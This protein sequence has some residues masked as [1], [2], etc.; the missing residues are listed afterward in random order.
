MLAGFV[1]P[2]AHFR[3][4][5]GDPAAD[6]QHAAP[7][8]HF[9][10]ALSP[11]RVEAAP[12]DLH[13]REF[14]QLEVQVKA[15][16]I[17]AAGHANPRAMG[18]AV[19]GALSESF[20][21]Y[22]RLLTVESF[23]WPDF[24]AALFTKLAEHFTARFGGNLL[25]F[26]LAH[27]SSPLAHAT[28]VA[29][30]TLT[31]QLL[32]T[33][34]SLL[35]QDSALQT[36]ILAKVSAEDRDERTAAVEAA[37]ALLPLSPT[38]R[39]DIL[40]LGLHS[41]ST[42]LCYLLGT[43][44]SSS[45]EAQQAWTHC[46]ELYERL[47]DGK[48][49]VASVR[50]MTTL[51]AAYPTGL[52][53]MHEQLLNHVL[54]HDP[55][56]LVRNFA[57]LATQQLVTAGGG[58]D[59]QLARVLEGIFSRLRD[60]QTSQSGRE[61]RLKLSALLLLEKWSTVSSE[62]GDEAVN[63]LAEAKTWVVSEKD[64]RFG[65]VY[66]SI[67]ANVAQQKLMLAGSASS[68]QVVDDLLLLLHPS[69]VAASIVTWTHALE[70]VARLSQQFPE[71]L[72]AYVSS[73]LVE[74][75]SI[76]SDGSNNNMTISARKTAIFRVLSAQLRPP[77]P[78]IIQMHLPTLLRE[79]EQ[80]GSQDASLLRAL[81]ATFFNWTQDLSPNSND[82]AVKPT[83]AAFEQ[84][85]LIAKHYESHAERY[86]MTKLAVLH[87]RFALAGQLVAPIAAQADSECFGGWL[88]ALQ[89][90]CEAEASVSAD[91]A[92][93]L[94]SLHAL[95]RARTFLQ[96]AR[97][98]SFR[99]EFQLHLLALRLEW[100]QLVQ[101]AQQLAGEAVFTNTAGNPSGREGQLSSQFR[102][103]GHKFAVLH[104]SL[105]GAD[106]SDLDVLQ[107]HSQ[108]CRLLAAALEGF[109]LLRPMGVIVFPRE[110]ELSAA[111][112]SH[113]G[114]QV[115]GLLTADV[116][117]K[118][119][120]L[121]KLS[122]ARQPGVGARVL[123]QLLAAACA[124]SCALPRLFFR[125]RLRAE[126]RLL[127]S[128]QFLTYAENAAFTAKPRSRSQ[129]GVPLGTDFTSVL[130][131]VL[132]LSSSALKH[133]HQHAE[134][135]EV[136]VLVCLADAASAG[137]GKPCLGST[138]YEVAAATMEDKLVQHRVRV[139]LPIAW[140][141]VAESAD[142]DDEGGSSQVT[143]YLPFETPVHVKA[144]SL[145]LK[146][147][148]LLLAKLALVDRHGQRWPLAATGCRRGFIVY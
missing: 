50:A 88:M 39:K 148:F 26:L 63:L 87:G 81:A 141:Q 83:I 23:P 94:E 125:S 127:S 40:T 78:N 110:M 54:D 2:H 131:G 45:A 46:A 90:L 113:K 95:T 53:G 1:V 145:K 79:L 48:S 137:V 75:L 6:S 101:R 135:I 69:G 27:L 80:A 111:D 57:L 33:M 32:A 147:S 146:G 16:Q 118:L 91:Q 136:E 93:Q 100:M 97:T 21:F 22:S 9:P 77:S 7:N 36:Q 60:S 14:A 144:A 120:R 107:S 25:R 109:L 138:I 122:P 5:H 15:L 24:L 44:V 58:D 123:Q 134:A 70:A 34:P 129:L 38:F 43:A 114:L 126:R 89:A 68:E 12:T 10:L 66:V 130:K 104:A 98:S 55:R 42:A 124:L 37:R 17:Q 133:W 119:A 139:Q 72:A 11:Q 143:L 132:A 30:R 96:A 74:L 41:Y 140:D 73:R 116:R 4:F 71:F 47:A 115:W 20:L 86:E 31:L 29:T 52:L 35:L 84:Q 106:Q 108:S 18:A 67:L 64:E 28:S 8:D 82:D 121:T 51:T 103:L 85:F 76:A 92:V 65:K 142:G 112:K 61:M 99:F 13:L 117:G 105:L 3:V 19:A 59:Q 49:A 102:D 128:A 56:G 62:L